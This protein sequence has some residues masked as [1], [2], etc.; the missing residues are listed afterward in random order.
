M[1]SS[2]SGI[3]ASAAMG[4]VSKVHRYYRNFD[5]IDISS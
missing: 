3:E 1:K 2:G 5:Q 4:M